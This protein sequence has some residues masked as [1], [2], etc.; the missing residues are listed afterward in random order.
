[1]LFLCSFDLI[2]RRLFRAR[3]DGDA[4]NAVPVDEEGEWVDGD[5]ERPGR[6]IMSAP[7]NV[8]DSTLANARP[9]NRVPVPMVTAA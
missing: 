1:M 9:V 5:D 3:G 6:V 8:T 4:V 7:A 2:Y